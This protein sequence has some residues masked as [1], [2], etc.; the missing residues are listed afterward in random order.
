MGLEN[1]MKLNK[2]AV[3]SIIVLTVILSF[4]T[5]TMAAVMADAEGEETVTGTSSENSDKDVPITV[6]SG[7]VTVVSAVLTWDDHEDDSG[8]F[9]TNEPDSL[10][11]Q[12]YQSIW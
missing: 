6:D 9:T 7:S 4:G 5:F 8:T 11:A 3:F 12:Y 1:R 10:Q 2:L